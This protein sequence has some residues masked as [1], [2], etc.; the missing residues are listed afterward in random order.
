M[1]IL[2]LVRLFANDCILVIGNSQY[3]SSFTFA[4]RRCGIHRAVA[5]Y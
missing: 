1:Q 2:L 4:D 5:S 3:E